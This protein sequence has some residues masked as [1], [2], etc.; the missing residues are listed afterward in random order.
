MSDKDI[1]EQ[2][3]DNENEGAQNPLAPREA[4]DPFAQQ[5]MP[6]ALLEF[7]SPTASLVNMPPSP[8]ALYVMWI[9]GG[10][11]IMCF[12]AAALFPMNKI[13]STPG[14]LVSVER[15]IIVQPL[16]MSIVRSID[17]NMGDV[18]QK[19]QIL[20]HLDP[21]LT[22]AEIDD[23][24]AQR[25]AYKAAVGRLKAEAEGKD[26]VA[27]VKNP[28][29]LNEAAAF[30][31]RRLEFAAKTEQYEQEIAS[32]QSQIQGYVASA[33]MYRGRAN[34]GGQILEMRQKLQKEAVGSRLMT[35]GAQGELIDAERSQIEAQQNANAAKSKLAA[36][37]QEL[38]AYKENWL[39]D[40]YAKL[41]EAQHHY[42]EAEGDFTKAK[43]RNELI[44]L[45]APE[46][47]VVLNV[48]KVS[49]GAV[50]QSAQV[51]VSLVP[52]GAALEME[53][54]LRGQDAGFV[55]LGDHALLKF[56]T[57]P[58]NQYGGA[59]ATVRVISADTF[60]NEESPQDG[61]GG[62]GHSQSPQAMAN[63]FYRVRLRIDRYTLHGVPSFFHPIP[64]MP[65]MANIQVG[66][67]TLM[68]YFFN[69]LTAATSAGL[70]EP[71]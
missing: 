64:G 71:S 17:V 1:V 10:M 62:G 52:T 57:F 15:T 38:S 29:S 63:G 26:Y 69:R 45:R 13:V 48:A 30:L 51:L 11:F 31:K 61:G 7:H 4:D 65:V 41:S 60:T 32:L 58:Y 59:D 54:V 9:V 19:G 50:V 56:S 35:L 16:E 46:D 6:L 37:Q 34:I 12:L 18:V 43:L 36:T 70:R 47:G 27:D 55:K 49:V 53:A 66:K 40:V 28:Y 42:D 14:R 21:T 3:P 5:D 8:V 68:Q 39:A 22:T 33:A 25:D 44:L 20:A 2:D 23:K 24:R 67:R